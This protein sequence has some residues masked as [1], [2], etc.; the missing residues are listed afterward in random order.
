[1]TTAL[2]TETHPGEASKTRPRA[3]VYTVESTSETVT[4]P[5][6]KFLDCLRVRRER[7]LE[8]DAIV[9]AD[10][11]QDE[12]SKM[13]WFAPGVG[14]VREENLITGSREELIDY[15]LPED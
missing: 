5:A 6:G 4:V 10:I 8:N 2:R 12:Q 11:T 14:K 3:H 1:M 7:D 15:E 9:E 13:F